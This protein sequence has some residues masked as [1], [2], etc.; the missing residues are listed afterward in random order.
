MFTQPGDGKG[1]HPKLM[2]V[3]NHRYRTSGHENSTCNPICFTRPSAHSE[4]RPP[5]R[6]DVLEGRQ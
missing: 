4:C 6:I 2:I 3:I 5:A 1:P